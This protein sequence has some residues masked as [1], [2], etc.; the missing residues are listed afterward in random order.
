[1]T[2]KPF[3][4]RINRLSSGNTSFIALLA[5]IKLSSW[6]GRHLNKLVT[7]RLYEF[8]YVEIARE[9]LLEIQ[10]AKFDF[11]NVA[12]YNRLHCN[13]AMHVRTK[14]DDSTNRLFLR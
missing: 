2:R 7:D 8:F 4:Y 1:M 9:F 6:S 11:L 12:D 10:L 3:V 5:R 13:F 14:F